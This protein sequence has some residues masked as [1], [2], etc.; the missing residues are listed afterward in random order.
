MIH[1]RSAATS[2]HTSVAGEIFFHHRITMNTG[3]TSQNLPVIARLKCH[4]FRSTD[5]KC[6]GVVSKGFA[7]AEQFCVQDRSF[8]HGFLEVGHVEFTKAETFVANMNAHSLLRIS[9][10]LTTDHE[11]L[12]D[13]AFTNS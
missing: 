12:H 11:E 6:L 10:T 3:R 9:L 13:E 5:A 8:R 2:P 7:Q 4:P 1:R